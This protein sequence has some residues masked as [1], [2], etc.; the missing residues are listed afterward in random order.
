MGVG[1]IWGKGWHQESGCCSCNSSNEVPAASCRA[2]EFPT[3]TQPQIP[4]PCCDA[5]CSPPKSNLQAGTWQAGHSSA[6]KEHA[7]P[8]QQLSL[9]VYRRDWEAAGH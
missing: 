8:I 5:R 6:S 4:A 7:A 3:T 2:A 9:R 1:D